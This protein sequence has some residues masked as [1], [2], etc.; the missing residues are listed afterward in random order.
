MNVTKMNGK[1][2]VASF[3]AHNGTVLNDPTGAIGPN[4][5]VYAFNSGFGILDRSGNV[6]VPEASLGTLFP[7]ETLGDPIVVYDRYA[8][9]FIIMEF[10]NT[11]N[12]IL[13]AVCQG[14]DPVNDGW[15]T[16]RFNTGTFPDYEKLSV[17][18]DGYYITENTG[19]ANK[20]WALER[21]A[22]LNGDPNAQIVSYS[23]PGLVTSGFHSPQALNVTNANLPAAGGATIVYMQ[24]DAWSGVSNDHIKIWT[25]D[26]NWN[27]PG[28]STVSA[29]QEFP[30]TPFIGNPIQF[31]LYLPF[32]LDSLYLP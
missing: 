18:S 30:T 12:G 13:I 5:Y 28:S 2:P 27:N 32:L 10:S 6:L 23:L 26:T 9:R 15:Y 11:P 17:W 7:N 4:H 1:A 8:D 31:L 20:V 25:I 29:A 3:P 21:A 19:S 24:D 16:Y 22:M 14:P